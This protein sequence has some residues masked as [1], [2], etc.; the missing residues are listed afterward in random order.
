MLQVPGQAAA[1]LVKDYLTDFAAAVAQAE[2]ALDIAR[3]LGDDVLAV[4]ALSLVGRIRSRQ[5]DYA[6]CLDLVDE[7][8]PIARTLDDPRLA[9]RLLNVQGCALDG[10]GQ[11]GGVPIE[12]SAALYR[13]AGDRRG[14]ALAVNNMGLT[15]MNAGD[16]D[17]ARRLFREA[18]AV[19][20]ELGDQQGLAV[21]ALNAGY[22]AALEDDAEAASRLFHECL[23]SRLR[24]ADHARLRERM[25]DRAFDDAYQRGM[26][27]PFEEALAIAARR[28]PHRA[29]GVKWAA[30]GAPSI[31]GEGR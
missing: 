8:L 17:A 9:A 18:V 22:V 10:L 28:E 4:K 24:D 26:H 12:E 30:A 27:L 31:P 14:V 11:D 29:A 23:E 20:R 21:G 6:G 3:D 19:M 1:D 7:A 13:R 16:L 5:G 2:E 15:A 25:G